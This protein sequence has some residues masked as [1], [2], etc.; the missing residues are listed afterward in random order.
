MHLLAAAV[1]AAIVLTQ[2]EFP[3]RY[4]QVVELRP[5]A[6]VLVAV[7]NAALLAALALGLRALG[8]VPLERRREQQLLDRRGAAPAVRIH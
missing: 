7:R 2:V 5:S 4:L 8:G 6:L 3:A 1:G